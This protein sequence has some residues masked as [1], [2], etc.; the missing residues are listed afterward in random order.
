[1][2]ELQKAPEEQLSLAVQPQSYEQLWAFAGLIAKTGMVPKQYQ[3]KPEDTFVAMQWG[4]ELGLKPLQALQNIATI[5]GKPS[6]YG[7]AM[8]ALV[9][10]SPLCEYVTEGYDKSKKEA[11]CKVKRKGSPEESI[12]YFGETEAKRAGLLGKA[13]PWTQYTERMMRFRARGFA[14]RD[15]FPDVL[16]GLITREEAEDIPVKDVDI[17]VVEREP[18]VLLATDKNKVATI[19]K[20]K[21]LGLET[22]IGEEEK[23]EIDGDISS[24]R[25]K[26]LFL[27]IKA[28]GAALPAPSC[29][30]PKGL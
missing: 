18:D 10:Q 26:E 19:E 7:D 17:T 28:R 15:N 3:G 16:Q 11:W 30:Y 22:T 20:L 6:I 4:I 2:N 14:L 21:E 1:M 8:L 5:N 13:G 27:T 23:N 12:A 9:H 25:L 29:E 24:A